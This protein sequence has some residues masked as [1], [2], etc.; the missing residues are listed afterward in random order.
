MEFVIECQRDKYQFVCEMPDGIEIS[1]GGIYGD[2]PAILEIDGEIFYCWIEDADDPS[3][4][5][6]KVD[7]VSVCRTSVLDDG[8]WTE[9]SET[10]GPVLVGG[11]AEEDDDDETAG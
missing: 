10:S 6:L 1:S 11:E 8:T 7:S 3:P 5:V 4:K 9:F 2:T